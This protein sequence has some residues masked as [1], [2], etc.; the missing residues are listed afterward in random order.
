MVTKAVLVTGGGGVG[1]T[2]VSAALGVTAARAG[3]RTLVITVDPA[4]RLATALGLDTL[5]SEPHPH[6]DEDNLWAAMIDASASWQALA[7]RHADPDVA[8]RLVENRFFAAAT[9][10]FPASQSYAAAEE[11]ARFL[12]AGA[13]ELVVID[14]PPAAGGLEFFTAPAEMTDLIGGRLLRWITGGRLPGRKFF[15]DR[16]ARPVLRIADH[17]LG[18]G[19]LEDIAKFLIDMRTTYDGIARRS[20]E[21]EA[22]LKKAATVV[23]TTADPAPIREAVRMFRGLPDVAKR[24]VAVIFN[25]TLPTEWAHAKPGKTTA[26]LRDNLARWGAEALRQ[27]DLREEFA[28]R[29]RTQLADI[30][31]QAHAPTDL[32]SLAALIDDAQGFDLRRLIRS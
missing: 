12:D 6:P 27:N 26:A 18:A 13:W 23:V 24:P 5:G 30:P 2:T 25:R 28:S 20:R 19:L 29:Y 15:F 1:K 17:V 7:H 21:I 9:S 31:W 10:H 22:Y 16:A 14:T 3:V 8:D 11:A 4:K 32:D